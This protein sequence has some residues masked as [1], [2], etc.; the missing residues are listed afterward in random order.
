MTFLIAYIAALLTFLVLDALWL[1]LVAL[2][3]YKREMG[4]LRRDPFLLWPAATFYLF[5][6]A[7]LVW[8]AVRPY[9]APTLLSVALTGAGVGG[10]AFGAYDMTNLATL[11]NWSLKMSLVDIT[12]GMTA[13]AI[14]S[15]SAALA[16]RFFV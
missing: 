1:G 5:F 15:V 12:W 4:D 14:V 7:G 11:K 10:L 3:F 16:V 6:A 2:E 9:E 13:S 8:L